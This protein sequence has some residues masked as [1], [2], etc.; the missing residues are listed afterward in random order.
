MS[1]NHS[2]ATCTIIASH[3]IVRQRC[4]SRDKHQYPARRTRKVSKSSTKI[5]VCVKCQDDDD[6]DDAW[7]IHPCSKRELEFATKEGET[8]KASVQMPFGYGIRS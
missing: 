1:M 6:D 7:K 5:L 4:S 3:R 2:Q 8:L